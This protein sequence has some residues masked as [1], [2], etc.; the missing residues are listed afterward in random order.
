VGELKDFKVSEEYSDRLMV[1]YADGFELL[2]KYL[3]KHHPDLNF[4]LLEIWRRL[5][6]RC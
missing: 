3:I 4:S 1:E 5:K 6:R 2:Q